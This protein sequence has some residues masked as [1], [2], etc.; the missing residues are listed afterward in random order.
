MYTN[1]DTRKQH[2][3]SHQPAQDILAVLAISMFPRVLLAGPIQKILLFVKSV[4][5][6]S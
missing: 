6:D 5:N 2:Q 3:V 4:T 1:Y